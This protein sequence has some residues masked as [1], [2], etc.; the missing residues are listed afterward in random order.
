MNPEV[1]SELRGG[2]P[3]AE[4]T[5]AEAGLFLVRH[6]RLLAGATLGLFAAATVFFA[7]FGS[8]TAESRFEA[9]RS[10]LSASSLAG[11]ASQFGL[12]LP[13]G[14]NEESVDFY[15]ALLRS[16]GVF[17]DLAQTRFRFP[18]EPGGRDSVSGVLID[19]LGVGGS[20]PNQR[21]LNAIDR[22]GNRT[23]VQTDLR[24]NVITVVVKMPWPA[25]AQQV[26]R[27]ML[28]IVDVIN[29]QKRRSQASAEREFTQQ[30]VDDA[31][32]D[33]GVA[34]ESMQGFLER[35]RTYQQSPR[36]VFEYARLQRQ[37]E[38]RQQVFSLLSEA[39]ERA[40]IEEVRNTPVI[41]VL[42]P[43]ELFW[44]RS[45]NPLVMGFL[46]GAA[47]FVMALGWALFRSYVA[48]ERVRHA[49]EYEQLRAAVR[50]V[51]PIRR[52]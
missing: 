6:V 2:P 1:R 4:P 32:H 14:D 25:L 44:R 22:L 50:S 30:R 43:P 51:L 27:R 5:M 12:N 24:A 42:E 7:V 13:L 31:K 34:E 21:L 39:L 9:T 38:L 16:P 36:L 10:G 26:N 41:A 52:R 23:S 29:S 47:G 49:T 8:Y 20:S 37:I 33:L 3:P 35:N 19:L 28:E 46:A 45:K 40:R 18:K 11:I 15:A 48:S 17:A